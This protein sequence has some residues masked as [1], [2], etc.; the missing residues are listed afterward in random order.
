[1]NKHPDKKKKNKFTKGSVAAEQN[2]THI[3][4]I[5]STKKNLHVKMG[6]TKDKA[7]LKYMYGKS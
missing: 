1:M 5:R 7:V 2:L 4:I 6:N 3:A